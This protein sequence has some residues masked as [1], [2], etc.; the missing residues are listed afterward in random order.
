MFQPKTLHCSIRRMSAL[1]TIII[2]VKTAVILNN[3]N[4]I[5]CGDAT[6]I[7][8][9]Y[10]Y[11]YNHKYT[12][13]QSLLYQINAALLKFLLIVSIN[14]CIGEKMHIQIGTINIYLTG[15]YR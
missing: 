8:N 1:F 4:V 14:D 2:I 15:E 11:K 10:N 9:G 12:N 6:I 13:W 5:M 3:G 7:C